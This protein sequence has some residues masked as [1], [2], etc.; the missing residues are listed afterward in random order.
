M[1]GSHNPVRW[2]M[3][4]TARI[5][6]K[7]WEA[8]RLSGNGVVAAV[9]GRDRGKV[10]AFIRDLQVGN[11]AFPETPRALG[12]YEELLEARDI[13]AVYVPLPTGIRP[14]WLIKAAEAG[15]HVVSEKPCAPSA[16][17]LRRVLDA[18]ARSGV[19]FM[20]GVMFMHG[21]R[22][23]R[24]REVLDDGLTVGAL[25]RVST[26][27]SFA[28]DPEFF[29]GNIRLD[30]QLEPL[31]C[32]GDLGWY[33]IR[34]SLWAA[35]WQWPLAVTGRL[36]Q[37]FQRVGATGAVPLRFSGELLYEGWSA[38]FT[39]SFDT[40]LQQWAH[41][42]GSLGGIRIDDFVVPATGEHAGFWTRGTPSFAADDLGDP[43]V[44]G[45]AT[46]LYRHFAELV[47][48]GRPDPLWPDIAW[49]T[50]V[51]MEACL[52]SAQSGGTPVPTTGPAG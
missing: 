39:C 28:G 37:S 27:F 11:G 26:H 12:S 41:V 35:K 24:L 33:C 51:V 19:Q 36:L 44:N 18:C 45:Q 3:M 40:A 25:R 49:R 17:E 47:R 42:D 8:I 48:S 9:A 22:L 38:G 20:D 21:A 1:A 43:H 32:L 10:E 4:S 52:R 7:V 6:R 13:D 23:A 5:G 16:R 46:R 30:P 2:G 50:Q 14:Q 29:G 31:G 34:F 15:K